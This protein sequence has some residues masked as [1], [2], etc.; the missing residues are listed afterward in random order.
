MYLVLS[1]LFLFFISLTSIANENTA[2]QGY[3]RAGVGLANDGGKQAC[4][5]LPGAKAKYRLGNE[6][7]HYAELAVDHKIDIDST[8]DLRYIGMLTFLSQDNNG[9]EDYTSSLANNYF[10]VANFLD[11]QP[12]ASIWIGKRYYRRHDI[13]INDFFY[14]NTSGPGGGIE[15]YQLSAFKLSYALLPNSD[16][17][18]NASLTH[19]LRFSDIKT[20][21][22]GKLT[23][24][25]AVGQVSNRETATVSDTGGWALNLMHKHGLFSGSN[26][27]TLQYGEGGLANPGAR[28]NPLASSADVGYRIRDILLMNESSTWSSMWTVVYEDIE[29]NQLSTTWLSVG[30]RPQYHFNQHGSVALELGVDQVKKGSASNS[31]L[32]KV[33]IAAQLSPKADFWSR[34]VFRGFV[35]YGAWNDQAEADGIDADAVFKSK[36]GLTFGVQSE[37]WW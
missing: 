15:N 24:G 25:L 8:L 28:N 37:A 23:L 14:W 16:T 32:Y 6:C 33:T 26:S 31:Q 17:D 18:G 21:D 30:A 34:P 11:N 35:T 1:F 19:D 12:Q 3:V 27:V 36:S 22:S 20:G 9:D 4:F 5:K 13:H 7:E 2:F 29:T 10:S